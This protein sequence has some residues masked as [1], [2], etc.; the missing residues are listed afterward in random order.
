VTGLGFG[1]LSNALSGQGGFTD[2][3]GEA[4]ASWGLFSRSLTAYDR[5][6]DLDGLLNMGA[7]GV[8][9]QTHPPSSIALGLPLLLVDYRIWLSFWV[10]AS[11]CAI[12]LSLRVMGAP[13][14][15]AYP[16][17]IGVC[18]TGPGAGSLVTTYPASALVLALAWRFR[19]QASIA[20]VALG[21][22]SAERGVGALLCLYPAIRR[23]WRVVAVAVAMVLVLTVIAVA[24]EPDVIH[25]FLTQGQASVTQNLERAESYTLQAILHRR[26]L[27]VWPVW[28]AALLVAYF[29]WRRGREPYWVLLWFVFAVTPLGWVYSTI[30]VIP[31]AVA[32]W[33]SGRLGRAITLVTAVLALATFPIAPATAHLSWTVVVISMG[34]ALIV[35][36]VG[37][38]LPQPMTLNDLR[39]RTDDWD[40]QVR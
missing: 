32:T 4:A 18:L 34:L 23:K 11:A 21:L 1:E 8:G 29:A 35:S 5:F 7:Y 36:P 37:Q 30:Q 31:L 20:G 10:V 25:G 22:F 39:R 3:G 40:V 28:I 17:A 38:N 33:L 14:S 24:F 12:A 9:V 26:G 16:L 27:P 6:A 19:D 13:I 15:I 2:I